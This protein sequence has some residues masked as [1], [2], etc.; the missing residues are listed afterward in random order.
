ML[1]ATLIRSSTLC[2]A[3]LQ[4]QLLPGQLPGQLPGSALRSR[5]AGCVSFL[6]H[7][8]QCVSGSSPHSQSPSFRQEITAAMMAASL[9]SASCGNALQEACR[10]PPIPFVEQEVNA[11]VLIASL[12][13]PAV[14]MRCRQ[15]PRTPIYITKAGITAAIMAASSFSASCGN[16]LQAARHKS[17][18]PSFR[19]EIAAMMLAASPSF[20]SCGNAHQAAR[21][22]SSSS[23]APCDQSQTATSG[24]S[25]WQRSHV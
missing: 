21:R 6:R 15:S 5:D 12:S 19:Q 8:W 22:T 13:Q 25:C 3:L 24:S 18:S 2:P 23:S 20:V 1:A 7:L 11:A 10:T 16:A 9:S 4:P 17:S 14:V